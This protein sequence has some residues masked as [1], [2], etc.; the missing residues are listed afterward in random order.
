MFANLFRRSSRLRAARAE[1][2]PGS[3][4]YAIGDVHGCAGLLKRLHG[5]IEQDA[6]AH[7]GSRKLAIYL[8]DYIDRGPD[9]RGVIELLLTE[10]LPGFEFVFLKGNHED[11]LLRFLEDSKIG[12]AWLAYGGDA[13]LHNYAI[14]A[15]DPADPDALLAA[16]RNLAANAP[17]EHLEFLRRCRLYHV[18]GDY[19]FVHAG[20]RPNVTIEQQSEEDMLWIREEF[21]LSRADFGKVVVHGHSITGRPDTRHNRIGID[22][23]AYATGMLTCVVLEG[24]ERSFLTT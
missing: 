19:A 23:G 9:S 21:T 16:Q 6:A 4:L 8:G 22:T 12:P 13:T 11:S 15:P 5:L 2:P 7:P 20:F 14:R 17:T 1:V 3:R 10:P 18:E 24:A